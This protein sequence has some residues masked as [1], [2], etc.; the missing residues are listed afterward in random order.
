M[1]DEMILNFDESGNLGKQGR[2]FTIA[3]V[4]GTNL[5]PLK[6]VMNKSIVKTKQHFPRFQTATEIKASDSNPIIKE[7]FL[8]KIASKDIE[9]RYIVADLLH[10]Q[11]HLLKD[12]NLLYNYMLK[13]LILP[14]CKTNPPKRLVLNF[15]KRTIKV[16]STNSFTDYIK[17]LVNYELGLQ[18]PIEVKYIE[19]HNSVAIQA[20]DFVAN[21]IN[22]KYEYG[23][24]LFYNLLEEKI[25]HKEHFPYKYFGT[26]KVLSLNIL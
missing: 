25:V 6:N 16:G 14:I 20:A 3:C 5:K 22:T 17:I 11:E 24:D 19:S 12:E 4:G 21:A 7:Y 15:D 2:F 1:G 26:E 9:I 13:F 8:T 18:I 10:V 23:Y